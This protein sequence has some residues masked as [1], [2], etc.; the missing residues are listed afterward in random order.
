MVVDLAAPDYEKRFYFLIFGFDEI[1]KSN[2]GIDN[3]IHH[4]IR[5]DA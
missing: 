3:A 1:H 2:K 4:V 5:V